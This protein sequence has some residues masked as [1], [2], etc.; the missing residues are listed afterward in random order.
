[1]C[2]ASIIIQ[3]KM[4]ESVLQ[5]H[6]DWGH[7]RKGKAVHLAAVE[8]L[9]KQIKRELQPLSNNDQKES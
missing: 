3:Q 9:N 4:N 6:S 5:I 8:S 2:Q 7:S 1:M